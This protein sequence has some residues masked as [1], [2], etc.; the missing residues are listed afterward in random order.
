MH[1]GYDLDKLYDKLNLTGKVIRIG[2]FSIGVGGCS[3]GWEGFCEGKKV[4]VKVIREVGVSA[5]EVTLKRV[6]LITLRSAVHLIS[7]LSST[8][9]AIGER[10]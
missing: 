4:A 8:S 2:E 5:N 9:L 10:S 7:D 1:H 6:R 3:N